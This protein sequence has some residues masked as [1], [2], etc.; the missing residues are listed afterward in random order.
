MFELFKLV[1]RVMVDASGANQALSDTDRKA[2]GTTN[3][4]G[5]YMDKLKGWFAAAKTVIAGS[6]I[7]KGL[8]EVWDMSSQVAEIGDNIDKTSQK[9]MLSRQAYQKWAYV[10]E[11]SGTSI[12]K[13]GDA[14]YNLTKNVGAGKAE[15]LAL[16]EEL[17][18]SA[19]EAMT[20]TPEELFDMVVKGLRDVDDET[21][22]TYI[23]DTLLSGVAKDIPTIF[24]MTADEAKKLDDRYAELGGTM[25]DEL[26]DMSIELKDSQTDLKE[27]WNG[28]KNHLA[29]NTLPGMTTIIDGLT[30]ML[31][32]DFANGLKTA[33]DGVVD[34]LNGCLSAFDGLWQGIAERIQNAQYDLGAFFGMSREE[35]DAGVDSYYN[36]EFQLPSGEWVTQSQLDDRFRHASGIE[37]VPRNDYPATLHYGERV[38]TRQEAE[39]YNAGKSNGGN[40]T[41]N[42]QTVAQSPAQTAAAITAALARAR[43]AM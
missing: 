14:I 20:A 7:G 10:A 41:I 25:S 33:G 37:F 27:A 36:D 40:T 17:G 21:R 29:E 23:A 4:L 32:G 2:Q 35:V 12:D 16:L 30:L 3:N 15:T 38:L 22:R 9:F 5:G 13:I 18:I 34:Y 24:N 43:W 42:I 31:T 28:V 26:V 19:A 1:G 39:E 11:R 8:K 6:A